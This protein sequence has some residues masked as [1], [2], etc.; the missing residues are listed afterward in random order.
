[1]N[2]YCS[3]SIFPTCSWSSVHFKYDPGAYRIFFKIIYGPEAAGPGPYGPEA[4]GPG[5]FDPEAARP[6]PYDPE[7]AH[8]GPYG[9]EAAGP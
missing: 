9:P 3:R 6:G 4:A 2:V 8:P 1:M 7:A 5:P